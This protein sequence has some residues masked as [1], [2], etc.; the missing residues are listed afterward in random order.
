M[1]MENIDLI[2]N[3]FEKFF[4][5]PARH[6]EAQSW[7][8]H[9]FTFQGPLMSA[10]RAEDYVHQLTAMGGEMELYAEVWK[11]IAEGDTVATLVD[12]QSPADVIPY[13]Q[14]FQIH[15]GKIARLEVV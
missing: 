9:D 15:D 5:G 6:S 7:L 13:A 4:S 2:K 11:M 12:F 10:D 1:K 8:T 14:R 3:Y